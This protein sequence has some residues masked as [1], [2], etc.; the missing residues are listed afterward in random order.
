MVALVPWVAEVEGVMAKIFLSR[1][2]MEVMV[3]VALKTERNKYHK[4]TK[5]SNT[6]NNYR[7]W[8]IR[9]FVERHFVY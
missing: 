4:I 7:N 2:V 3:V 8:D 1:A 6:E 9:H 5:T